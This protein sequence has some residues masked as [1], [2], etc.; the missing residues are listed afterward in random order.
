MR[1]KL[2]LGAL[3]GNVGPK[4]S[5]RLKKRVVLTLPR[6]PI[7][8]GSKGE[9]KAVE[10]HHDGMRESIL[11]DICFGALLFEMCLLTV[12]ASQIGKS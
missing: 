12:K 5:L 4:T 8:P 3:G 2:S 10:N 9:P 7:V 11:S 1:N 6:T